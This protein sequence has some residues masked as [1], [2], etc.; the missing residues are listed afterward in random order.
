MNTAILY[1]VG[2]G[3]GDPELLTLKAQRIIEHCPIIAAPQTRSGATLAL[4]IV[5]QA[6]NLKDKQIL[7]LPFAMTRDEQ[8]L[9]QSHEKAVEHLI[10]ALQAGDDVAMLNIG[11]VSL[12][13]T[14]NHIKTQ[15][16]NAGY[17]T[18]M[19]PGIPSFCAV[20]AILDENLTPEMNTAVHIVP[21]D[22][23]EFDAMLS[24]DGTKIIMKAGKTLHD[25]KRALKKANQYE[26]AL[27]VQN[28]G[29]PGEKIVRSLDDTEDE[30]SYFSTLLV[31]P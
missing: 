2:V 28:C 24:L 5:Q 27:L 16:Q 6:V 12:Y 18:V 11:D 26:K 7:Y 20:A 10:A 21:A 3:P 31:T 4:D 25:V 14:F 19:I 1:G 8:I 22:A 29:L 13:A 15:V 9:K 17:R 30:G 23:A